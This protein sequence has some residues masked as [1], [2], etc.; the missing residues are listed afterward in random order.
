MEV[1][2]SEGLKTDPAHRRRGRK[3]ED[4]NFFTSTN[5]RRSF[6]H[7]SPSRSNICSAEELQKC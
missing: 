6:N 5:Q 3:D 1:I 2:F 7:P 4:I